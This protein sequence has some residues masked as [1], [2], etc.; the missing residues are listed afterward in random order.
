MPGLY[1]HTPFCHSKCAYCDFYSMPIPDGMAMRYAHAVAREF[2]MRAGAYPAF[3]TLY[4]GGGTPS[5]LPIDAWAAMM[6]TVPDGE[7]TI[8]VNPEDVTLDKARAWLD[9]GINR[10]SMGVQSLADDELAVIGRRHSASQAI[11]AYET[12]RRAGFANISLDLIYGLPGQSLESWERSLSTLLTLRPEHLSAYMLSYEPR[13]RLSAMLR[14]GKVKETDEETLEQMYAFLRSATAEAGY[15]H[16]EISN[17]AL[18]GHRARHNSSYWTGE[19][20]LGLG[21]G[22]HSFDGKDRWFNPSNLRLY[23]DKIESGIPAA[24]IDPEDDDSRFNDRVMTALRTADGLDLSSVPPERLSRLLHD[25]A[26]Y[27][28]SAHLIV[29]ANHLRIPT[30]SWLISDA[31]ISDLFQV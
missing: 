20:Y 28:R 9:L 26:P 25:A 23:L 18:P 27:Q 19:P 24:E 30:A 29:E 21:P 8:E 3:S 11:E 1:I 17:F 16:Y 14:A 13:T 2:E 15:E 5:I 4:L 31:I 6:P 22:A 12:L 7:V 10:A